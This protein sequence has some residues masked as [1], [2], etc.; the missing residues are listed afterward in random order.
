[1]SYLIQQRNESCLRYPSINQNP[2]NHFTHLFFTNGNGVEFEDGNPVTLVSFDRTIP[3]TEY[4]KEEKSFSFI[5]DYIEDYDIP[6]EIERLQNEIERLQNGND[7]YYSGKS[8]KELYDKEMSRLNNI[9]E[10]GKYYIIAYLILLIQTK[11]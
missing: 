9:K 8:Y 7:P 4:Y 6:N 10:L 3:W 1:M 11:P 5:K 2:I